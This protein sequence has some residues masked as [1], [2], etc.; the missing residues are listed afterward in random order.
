MER[1]LWPR[2]YQ[3]LRQVG[4]EIHQEGV[5]YQPWVIAAV[6]LWAALHDRGLSWACVEANWSTT[7]SRPVFLPSASTLSRR[8]PR[9]SVFWRLFEERLREGEEVGCLSFV[10]GKP[11]FVGHFSKDP[12]ARKGYGAGGFGKGY[13]LHA[14]WANRCLPEAWDV[15]SLNQSEPVIAAQL[16]AQA[17]RGGYL[18]ADG[19]Y[20]TNPL[21][22]AAGRCGYQLLA[23]QRRANA[24]RNPRRQSAWRLRGVTLQQQDFGGELMNQ[25]FRI[26]QRFG[27]LTSF[28]GGLAAL[29]AWVRRQHRVRTWVQAKLLINAIRIR[30]RTTT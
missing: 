12:D 22:E 20:D 17:A 15:V 7:R 29:P 25:R 6:V 19:N 2:L 24:G 27:Q 23:A 26:E 4:R 18:L 9:M 8:L 21:A 11:L 16:V 28:G 10:D 13:K 3:V 14:L 1:E 30:K 5:R